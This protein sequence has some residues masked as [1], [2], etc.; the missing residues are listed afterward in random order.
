[1]GTA[2]ALMGDTGGVEDLE[3][4]VAVA[5]ASGSAESGIAYL[6]LAGIHVYLGDLQ[7][8]F[9]LQDAARREVE[10][11]GDARISHFLEGEWANELYWRGRWDDALVLLD[12]LIPQSEQGGRYPEAIARICRGHIRLARGRDDGALA[13]ATRAL[14]AGRRAGDFQLVAPALAF[15]ARAALAGGAA[16]VGSELVD[17]LLERLEPAQILS[18]SLAWADLGYVLVRLG[19]GPELTGWARRTPLR[20]R[21]LE[22][23]LAFVGG[24][25]VGAANLYAEIGSRPDEAYARL[26]AGLTGNR[27]QLTPALA[28]F[29]A[30]H[31]VRY[32]ARAETALA[33]AD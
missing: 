24:D 27:D 3:R 10:R 4:S 15:K 22:A 7:V 9:R 12:A 25:F 26:R 8:A 23:A 28:F 29:S 13:D 11:S 31:A 30:V 32:T 17:E 18:A 5:Q 20:T 19:R 1:M 6:N 16:G 21:W 2:R 33:S 14:E